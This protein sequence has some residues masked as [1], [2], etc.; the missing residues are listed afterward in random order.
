MSGIGPLEAG[1][2]TW[3]EPPRPGPRRPRSGRRRALTALA[4][5]LAAAAGAGYLYATRTDPPA[6]PAPA[7]LP[8]PAQAFSVRYGGPAPATTRRDAAFAFAV[9]LRTTDGP[10]VT[11]HAIRQPS[12]ALSVT[13]DPAPPLTLAKGEMRVVVLQIAV[14]N[15]MHVPRNAGLPFLEVTLSNERAKEEHSYILGDRYARELSEALSTAC[16]AGRDKGSP[17]RS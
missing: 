15:C 10:P 17:V 14:T 11:V 6:V 5:A 16:P 4:L 7:E 8:Y 9:L 2:E 1:E 3:D 12:A 13:A